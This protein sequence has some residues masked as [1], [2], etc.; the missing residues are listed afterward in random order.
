MMNDDVYEMI[1]TNLSRV[2]TEGRTLRCNLTASLA[3]ERSLIFLCCCDVVLI[4]VE[5]IIKYCA[6]N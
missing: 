5:G 3:D 4:Y 2:L 1:D 6:I